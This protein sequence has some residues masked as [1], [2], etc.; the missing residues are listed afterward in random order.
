MNLTFIDTF[1][2]ISETRNFNKSAERL[3]VT[4]ST[5]SARMRALEEE[6]RT[7][8][9]R[10]GRFGAELTAAGH[11]LLPHAARLRN[12][13]NQ[14]RQEL[15]LP[16]GFTDTVRIAT[17]PSLY[18]AFLKNWLISMRELH[19]E[20]AIYVEAD[21]SPA[22][23]DQISNGT[24]DIGIIYIPRALPGLV[25]D[26]LY[27]EQ[28]VLVST[29]PTILKDIEFFNYTFIDW[30]PHFK[31]IHLDLL[32]H[33]QATPVSVGLGSMA[34]DYILQQG[35]CAYFPERIATNFIAN[36]QMHLVEDAPIIT[37]PIYTVVAENIHSGSAIEKA[38]NQL[39]ITTRN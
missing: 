15:A 16:E 28:F 7:P 8:L 10:R 13:W 22:V 27:D 18:D 19:P 6:L 26:R 34:V 35:G 1:L 37:Q 12:I 2:D 33:L 32:P 31:K 5:V 25:I 24:V 38:I 30:S 20:I 11:K 14:A 36:G 17:Q 4:Q 23:L 39:I 3:N 21:Y 9:F 29:K